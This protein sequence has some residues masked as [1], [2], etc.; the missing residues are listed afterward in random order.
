MLLRRL[1]KPTATKFF[2]KMLDANGLP[3]KIVI[4]KSGANTASIQAINEC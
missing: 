1:N 4:N 3:R 2:A